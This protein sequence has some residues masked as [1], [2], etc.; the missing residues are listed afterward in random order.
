MIPTPTNIY[1]FGVRHFGTP[2][3]IGDRRQFYL[4]LLPRAKAS[5]NK[6]GI[7]FRGLTFVDVHNPELVE[8]ML[9]TQQKRYRLISC[10]TQ[11]TFPT[12]II[13]TVRKNT[14]IYC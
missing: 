5:L 13:S 8:L 1:E 4:N 9:K 7:H 11:L 6:F 2:S 14:V 10:M 12:F 3:F